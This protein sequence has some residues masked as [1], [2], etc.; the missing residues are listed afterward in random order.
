MIIVRVIGGLG[1]QMFQ[2]ALYKSLENEGKEVKLDLTGFGDYD[3]HNGYE[4]NKI[5]N[6]NENVATK[7]EINKL[8]KLPDNK[9][10]SMIKRKFFSS[11]INYYSQDQFKYLS[12]IFQLDNVYLDGYWQSE[13]YFQGIK[14]VI[15]KEFKFKGEPNP[16]NIEM[17]KLMRGS[18]SVSIH[19]RRGDY[20]SNP[21]AYKVHGGITTIHYYENAVKEI[22]SKVKEPKFFIFSDDI[23][24][25][26]ENFKLE[27][28][29][30]I[31]W[32]TGSESYRDIELMSNCKHNI[33]ANST[34]SWWGAWLNKN[35]NKI[36]IAP[37]QWFNTI[38]TEDVIPDTW[39][40]INTF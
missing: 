5:F 8:I 2:Y 29:F 30:F 12:E 15:R 10:L 35:K 1:N 25:V 6:I 20:I 19:F 31:D 4:L 36:V 3:L 24:W 21:D 32:N 34:F 16:K 37:N 38:D 22:K 14:E 40:C 27:D 13:K 28:A 17:V 11:T 33:I 7:D 39:Q 18:N 9:V 23:K 26:K